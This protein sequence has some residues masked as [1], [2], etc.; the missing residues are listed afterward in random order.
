MTGKAFGR[1]VATKHLMSGNPL[2]REPRPGLTHL[3]WVISEMDR[4]YELKDIQ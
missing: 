3:E 1:V 2:E 4:K